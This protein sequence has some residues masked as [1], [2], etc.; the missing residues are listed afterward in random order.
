MLYFVYSF[1]VV[2]YNFCAPKL[3]FHHLVTMEAK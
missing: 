1:S 3:F 2:Q